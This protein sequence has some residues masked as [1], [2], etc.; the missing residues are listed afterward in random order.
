MNRIHYG[1]LV[2][3]GCAL[4]LFCTS[5]LCINA[6]TIYQPYIL[7]QNHFTNAQSSSIIMVRNAFIFISMFLTGIYYKRFSLRCGMTFAGLLTALGFC[8]F[9][10]ATAYPL[11]CFAA[12]VVGF[13]YGF[14]TMIPIAIILEHWFVRKRTFAI[15]LCSAV[16][17]LSTLGIPSLLTWMIEKWGLEITFFAEAAFIALMSCITFLLVRDNPGQ[18]GMLPFGMEQGAEKI[19]T[20]QNVGVLEKKHWILLVPALLFVGA[21]TNVGYSHLAVLSTSEGFDAHTTALAITIS[22]IMLTLSKCVYGWTSE[23]LG[24]YSSNWIFG[25]ILVA[26]MILCCVTNGSQVVL[27]AAMCAYGAGLALTTVGLVAWAGDLSSPQQYDRNVRRFQLGY[28]A[29]SLIFSS[30]PGVLADRFQGSYVPSYLFFMAGALFLLFSIQWTYRHV[31]GEHS[32]KA[33]H[34]RLPAIAAK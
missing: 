5:G 23:K 1:W 27:F 29:G 13:G 10:L 31:S 9:G 32:E 34:H 4:L 12:V 20:I 11:Y 33:S 2:C 7:N 6:F 22:G 25:I 3:L 30:L 24:T 19:K 16:T 28:A 21:V 15:G 8:L 14:G 18:K 17:G 26:G